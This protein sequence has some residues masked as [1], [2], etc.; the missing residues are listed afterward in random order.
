MQYDASCGADFEATNAALRRICGAYHLSCERWWEFRGN[1][2][3]RRIGTL[4]AADVTVSTCSVV[5]DQRDTHYLG[6]HYFLVFQLEGTARMRQC[7]V[8]AV[9]RPGES[10]LIDSRF[11]SVF[12]AAGGFRQFSFHLPTQP[13][14]ERFGSRSLP[15]AKTIRADRGPGLLLSD[16]LRSFVSNAAMLEGV[17]LTDLTLQL[18]AAA[19]GVSGSGEVTAELRHR[20]IDLREVAQFVDAHIQRADLSPSSIASHFNISLRQLYRI[21]HAHGYTPSGLIWRK[22]LEQAHRLLASSGSRVPIIEIAL[23]CGFKDGAHFS[24]SYRKMFGHSPRVSRN[25]ADFAVL[26]SED[27]PGADLITV[28]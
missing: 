6:D 10:T 4:D 13:L 23:N 25:A 7:G 9:L 12:E 21:V 22:R 26:A 16:M 24:R 20:S 19:L 18:L 1:L 14:R 17:D 28:S 11:P 2:R 3:T 5:R 27:I 15:A 8:E